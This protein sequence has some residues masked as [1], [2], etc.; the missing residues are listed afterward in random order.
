MNSTPKIWKACLPALDC[1][2]SGTNDRVTGKWL[3]PV[4]IE[5]WKTDFIP[6]NRNS[7]PLRKKKI[8]FENVA[9]TVEGE[10]N[11]VRVL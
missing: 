10:Q 11:F 9:K 2:E 1:C 3:G 4:E 5:K 6:R 8:P 7:R